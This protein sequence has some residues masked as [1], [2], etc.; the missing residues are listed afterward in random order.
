M[1]KSSIFRSLAL[2][3][4]GFA[5]SFAI[6]MSP[7]VFVHADSVTEGLDKLKTATG[8]AYPDT[9]F[10]DKKTP[11]EVLGQII[12]IMLGI[13]FAVAVIMVIYGGYQYI[14][15]AGNEEKAT[16]GRQTILY[17]LIGIV[18]IILSFVIVRAVVG[19]VKNGTGSSNT[20]TNN[21]NGP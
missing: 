9:V 20:S 1:S 13:A 10:S 3:A 16:S 5:A 21:R 15:S 12:N 6:A 7:A 4:V 11:S 18:I 17:A 19:F 8:D 14:T 2:L